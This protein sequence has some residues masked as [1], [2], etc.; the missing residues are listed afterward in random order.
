MHRPRQII[1]D[2]KNPFQNFTLDHVRDERGQKITVNSLSEL[3]AAEKRHNFCLAVASDDGG[4][5][6]KPPQHEPWAGDIAHKY[7][8]KWNRNPE[9][10]KPEN[11]TGVSAGIAQDQSGT[12]VDRP[13]PV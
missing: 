12:L 6:D 3:R 11:V 4:R 13:N 1:D 9:A 10:Y 7:E 2:A 8:K 5:A